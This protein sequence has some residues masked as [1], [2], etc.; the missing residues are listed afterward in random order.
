MGLSP[1]TAIATTR[2][3]VIFGGLSSIY[4]YSKEGIIEWKRTLRFVPL[5]ILGGILGSVILLQVDEQILEK[6]VGILLLLLVPVLALSKNFG[7]ASIQKSKTHHRIGLLVLIL[8]MTYN[9]FFGGGGGTFL[10]YTLIFFYGMS[11]IQANANGIF[12]G[13]FTAITSMIVFLPAGS[14]NFSYGV[15]MMTGAMIGSYLGA[16]TAVKKGNKFVRWVF[17]VIVITSSVKLVFF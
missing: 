5:A 16:H 11:V 14:V 4:K 2:L 17:L 10:V 6:A 15:P 3:N 1:S 12:L 7:L 8:V 9:A 13:F